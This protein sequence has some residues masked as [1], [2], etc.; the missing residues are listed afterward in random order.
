MARLHQY[1]EERSTSAA[2]SSSRGSFRGSRSL[3]RY[4]GSSH[5]PGAEMFIK[6]AKLSSCVSKSDLAGPAANSAG[7]KVK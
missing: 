4:S 6:M 1:R 7:A 2:G 5:D 3:D